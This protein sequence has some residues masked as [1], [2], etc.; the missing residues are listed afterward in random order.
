MK[1]LQNLM[2][3]HSYT[4]PNDKKILGCR[5]TQVYSL[6]NDSTSSIKKTLG[7]DQ[8]YLYPE[9]VAID[10]FALLYYV[11]HA[12]LDFYQNYYPSLLKENNIL[13]KHLSI[14]QNTMLTNKKKN[15]ER[16]KVMTGNLVILAKHI[17]ATKNKYHI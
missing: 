9:K 3:T 2:C 4:K 5:P 13:K 1:D 16:L 8:N 11:I 14:M 10:Q 6:S 15:D 17:N 7:K 12:L